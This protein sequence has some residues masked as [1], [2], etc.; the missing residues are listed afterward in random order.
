MAEN[1]PGGGSALGRQVGGDH[2]LHLTI[3]PA[4]YNIKNDL[5]WAEG[6]I[7]KYVSRWQRA[8]GIKDLRKA[9][10][11]LDILIEFTEAREAEA[12]SAT[13]R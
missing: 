1:E 2:Y 10:Q 4:E 8:G 12:H 9:R 13:R 5:R 11:L 7:V 6:S 3:Q